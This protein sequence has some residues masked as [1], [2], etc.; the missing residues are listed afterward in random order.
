MKSR[1]EKIKVWDPFIRLFHWCIVSLFFCNYLLS[2]RGMWFERGNTLHR[3]AGYIVIGFVLARLIWGIIGTKN[4][5]FANFIPRPKEFVVYMKALL[6][7]E[8]P[9]YEG[10]NPAGAVMIVFLLSGLLATGLTG[11]LSTL[12][13]V[14]DGWQASVAAATDFVDWGD[15]HEVFANLTMLAA[16]IHI[17]AVVVVSHM[18]RENLVHSMLSGYKYKPNNDQK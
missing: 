16:G 9:Y 18:T 4:A 8:H 11:W 15:V 7:G 14:F 6:R 17:T 3:Y 5:R 2:D 1:G 10:H 12:G 13:D